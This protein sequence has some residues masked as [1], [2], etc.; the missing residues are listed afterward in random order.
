MRPLPVRLPK[1]RLPH[2]L[3]AASLSLALSIAWADELPIR[4]SGVASLGSEKRLAVIEAQ[5]GGRVARVGDKLRGIG[6]ITEIGPDW[7]RLETV[8]GGEQ[9]IR[10]TPPAAP[11]GTPEDTNTTAEQTAGK[12]GAEPTASEPG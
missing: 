12:D 7:V 3:A 4:L 10:L 8:D 5:G 1:P 11:P 6:T 2:V 9:I